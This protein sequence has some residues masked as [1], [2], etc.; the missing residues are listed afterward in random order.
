MKNEFLKIGE[1]LSQGNHLSELF[2][3][4]KNVRRLKILDIVSTVPCDIKELQKRLKN[5]GY[6]HSCSTISEY[7]EPLLKNGLVKK[8][9]NRYTSTLY[10]RQ[11]NAM[12]KGLTLENALPKHSG[13][14]EEFVL[15]ELLHGAKSYEELAK[16]V[17]SLARVL[18]R[19]QEEGLITKKRSA[20]QV[21]Y[22]K[23]KRRF[24]ER[25]SPTERKVL[26][27]ISEAGISARQLSK[28][29][30]INLRRTYKYLRRLGDKQLI[31]NKNVPLTYELTDS[32]KEVANFLD[33]LAMFI[34]S[35][36][37]LSALNSGN[38]N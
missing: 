37:N 36:S 12:L 29:V 22:F 17:P 30:G 7:L 8:E 18:K 10:G 6:Y 21:F 38:N 32:G 34:S 2:N 31:F 9:G 19:L 15:R 11:I 23:T 20:D 27:A 25:L 1:F 4:V 33:E 13:C 28:L 3:A 26:T 14:Y 5:S 35:T 16:S 24:N